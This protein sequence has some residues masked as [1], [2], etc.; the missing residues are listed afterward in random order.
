M[1]LTKAPI[2]RLSRV[3]GRTNIKNCCTEPVEQY[4]KISKRS[5]NAEFYG[6]YILKVVFIWVV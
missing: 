3:R 4:L 5:S 2:P 1:G 6:E